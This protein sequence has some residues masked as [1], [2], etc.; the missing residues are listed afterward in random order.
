MAAEHRS[1]HAAQLRDHG[2]RVTPSRLAVLGAIGE[3]PGHPSTEA[4]TAVVRDRLG[5]ISTQT[6]YDILHTLTAAGLLRCIE[7]AGSPTR[8]ESRVGDNHHHL[9]CSSC[10]ATRDV[11]CAVGAAP[12]LEPSSTD[13]FTILEA[14]IIF[15]GLCPAC[16]HTGEGAIHESI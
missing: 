7:P 2:L 10:G 8:Y 15:W 16:Q 5:S 13:G 11:D 9:V 3:L 1:N 12:C 14:E 4:I 6:V